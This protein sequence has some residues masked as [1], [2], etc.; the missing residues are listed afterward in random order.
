[1][2]TKIRRKRNK[3][4]SLLDTYKISLFYNVIFP[5][6]FPNSLLVYFLIEIDEISLSKS[7]VLI[8]MN[9]LQHYCLTLEHQHLYIQSKQ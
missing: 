8:F 5:H 4:M 7:N 1:M 6:N 2:E 9:F 3:Y